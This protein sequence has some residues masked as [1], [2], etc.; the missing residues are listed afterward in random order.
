[1]GSVVC[2]VAF[3]ALVCTVV[4]VVSEIAPATMADVVTA[5]VT[6]A[7]MTTVMQTVVR[8]MSR[9]MMRALLAAVSGTMSRVMTGAMKT[10]INRA[11]MKAV[12]AAMMPVTTTAAFGV[13]ANSEPTLLLREA[14]G[15]RIPDLF[16]GASWAV[17]EA[18]CRPSGAARI[19]CLVIPGDG[20][21]RIRTCD[22]R[23]K[24][25]VLFHLS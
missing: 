15:V 13:A 14:Q 18:L 6:D 8:T 3:A 16:V 10:A 1:V 19:L 12:I 23:I 9:T 17:Q 22:H 11:M 21:C 2:D 25:Q 4:A 7:V 20:P 24:N 5:T